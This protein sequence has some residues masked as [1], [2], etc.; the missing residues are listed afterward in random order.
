MF[1]H[2]KTVQEDIKEFPIQTQV[3]TM[4]LSVRRAG[5]KNKKYFAAVLQKNKHLANRRVK[6]DVSLLK[7]KREDDY[8]LY[9]KYVVC[10]WRGVT[11]KNGK[12]VEFNEENCR[13]FL[14]AI[15]DDKFNELR[16]FCD[17]YTNFDKEDV[18][19]TAGN[20][21]AV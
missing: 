12:T 13:L 21:P 3:G 15:G 1:D 4:F 18:S 19:E 8:D 5:E 20:S 9:P 6:V 17:D 7:E 11:D 10:G 2:I 14:R 16:S